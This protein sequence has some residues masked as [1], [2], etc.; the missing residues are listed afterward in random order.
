[1]S[2][3]NEE[4]KVPT[5]ELLPLEI[6]KGKEDVSPIHRQI[7]KTMEVTE[8]FNV[9]ETMVY[10]AKMK[11]AITDKEAE[12]TGIQSMIEAYEKELM[13]IESQ[14]GIQGMEEL[15]QKEYA[16]NLAK[17]NEEA[18]RLAKEKQDDENNLGN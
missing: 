2:E 5:Y 8:T 9:Y 1:M 7:A 18:E 17:E 6:G 13:V 4:V 14:L 15:F 11:K 3:H 12:I 16:E 10:L